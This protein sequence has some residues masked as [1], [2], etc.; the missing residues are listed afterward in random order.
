MVI[1]LSACFVETWM[2]YALVDIVLELWLIDGL[3]KT[4]WNLGIFVD[5][6][7]VELMRCF[8]SSLT[9]SGDW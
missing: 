4:T 9:V 8:I 3:E 5:V 1:I 2:L 7:S 6:P